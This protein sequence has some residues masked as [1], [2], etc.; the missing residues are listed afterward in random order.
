MGRDREFDDFASGEEEEFCG[1]G[2]ERGGEDGAGGEVDLGVEAGVGGI[3]RV[4][5]VCCWDG[6]S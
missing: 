5:A 3:E 6:V 2:D 1:G 4:R